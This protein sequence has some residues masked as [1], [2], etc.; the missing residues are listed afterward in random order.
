M[1]NIDV[2]ISTFWQFARCWKNGETSKFELSCEN[3]SL[4]IH[5]SAK[6]GHPD[7]LHFP[8]PPPPPSP[9]QP[10]P[11][12]P[13]PPVSLK[14]KSP[15]QQRRQERRQNEKAAEA[16]HEEES[17]EKIENIEIVST[18]EIVAKSVFRCDQCDTN[19][20]YKE[21]L[22]KH[23]MKN[24]GI[25]E[26]KSMTENVRMFQ[27]ETCWFESINIDEIEAHIKIHIPL[28]IQS[29]YSFIPYLWIAPNTFDRYA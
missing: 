4:E 15:S 18:A 25:T 23:V 28:H 16:H 21:A 22:N 3:G 26:I 10:F 7:Q 9:F 2:A 6:L 27:Y 17:H 29:P 11:I 13:A 19:F 14:R 5:M 20:D 24:H 8:S 1:L 12:P